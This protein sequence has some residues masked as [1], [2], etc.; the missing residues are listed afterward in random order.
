MLIL[1]DILF[2]R[3]YQVTTKLIKHELSQQVQVVELLLDQNRVL[4]QEMTKPP[5]PVNL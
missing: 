2:L 3:L 5:I 4:R 1:E